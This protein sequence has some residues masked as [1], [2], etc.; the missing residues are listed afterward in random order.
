MEFSIKAGSPEKHRTGCVVVGVFDGRKLSASAEQLDGAA[1]GYL[2][3]V[4]KTGD[5]EGALGRTLLLHKVP[6]LAADRVL[7]VGLGRERDFH[8]GPYRTAVSAAVKALKATGATE[9]TFTLPEIA[10]KKRDIGWK[11]EHA[12]IAL[13]EGAYRFDRLKSKKADAGK[14]L[15]KVTLTVPRKN[16]VT[17][18]DTAVQRAVAIA[19]G[20]NLAK[21]LGNLP[22]NYCTPTYLADQAVELGKRHG[23]KV[24]VFD[25]KG[26]EK[27]GM[28]SF[29]A[30]AQG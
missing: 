16:D 14:A 28:G 19:E 20:M 13:M 8:E 3:D 21:D 27:L 4:L 7:L 22:G 23:I 12:V 6:S 24:E 29:L 9:A 11:V 18:G 30:V 15:K 17:E 1:R 2:S 10:L 25:L 26:I 5:L